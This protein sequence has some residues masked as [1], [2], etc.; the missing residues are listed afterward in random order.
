MQTLI[1]GAGMAGLRAASVLRDAN[2]KY[3][4]LEARDRV[5]GRVWTNRDLADIPVEFGAE[6]L[7]GE[8]IP[9]WKYVREL[10]LKTVFWERADDAM[11]MLNDGRLLTMP[12]ARRLEPDWD[13]TRA[14][15]LPNIPTKP[16]ESLYEYLKRIG[17]SQNALRYVERVTGNAACAHP[18][19]LSAVEAIQSLT[20]RHEAFGLEDHRIVEGYDTLLHHIADGIHIKFDSVVN[21]IDWSDEIIRVTCDDGLQFGADR[22]IITLPIGVLQSGNIRFYPPLPDEKRTSIDN[23]DMN[24]ILK[25][26]Y[27]FDEPVTPKTQSALYAKDVPTMWWS[28]TFR[29]DDTEYTVWTAFASDHFADEILAQP[30]PL[31]FGMRQRHF[32]NAEPIAAHL[33]N[34]RDDPFTRGGYSTVAPGQHDTRATLASPIQNRIF[35]AGEATAPISATATVHGAYL[36]GERA[37]QELLNS[38][39]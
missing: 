1:L 39:S 22:L 16:D 11:V 17:W 3:L 21:M 25:M 4:I 29:R 23:M 24:S 18:M 19:H 34:W 36:S 2:E 35:F 10:G 30:D 9:L 8:K 38:L 26:V 15:N 6:F 28:P 37:A 13:A 32:G 31:T 20:Q 14:W 27:V 12:D 33:V 7:H 5:G